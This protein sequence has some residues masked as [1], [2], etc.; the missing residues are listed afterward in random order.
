MVEG[1]VIT[2]IIPNLVVNYPNFVEEKWTKEAIENF[3]NEYNV[4]VDFIEEETN[5]YAEGT[6]L[7]QDRVAGTRV[8]KAYPLK[9]TIAVPKE[10]K[11]QDDELPKTEK[12]DNK[13][14]EES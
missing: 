2:F 3:C 14:E 10:E 7:K 13:P 6:I 4:V 9:I 8:L 1:D 12:E 5:S 11:K